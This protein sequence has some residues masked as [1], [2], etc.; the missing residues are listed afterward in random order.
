MLAVVFL[1]DGILVI[2]SLA[3]TLLVQALDTKCPKNFL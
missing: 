1:T 2:F 3:R